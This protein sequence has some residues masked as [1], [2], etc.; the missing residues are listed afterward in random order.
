LLQVSFYNVARSLTIVFNVILSFMILRSTVSSR[1]LLCLFLVFIGFY[2]G[3]DGEVR[4]TDRR[5]T[6]GLWV[7]SMSIDS[8]LSRRAYL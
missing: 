3:S 4:G 6:I 8:R 7:R 1:T 5:G 2:V